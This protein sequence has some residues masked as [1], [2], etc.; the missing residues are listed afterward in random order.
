MAI[1]DDDIERIRSSVSI[2]DVISQH[3]QLRRTGRNWVGLC[4]FHGEK[5]PSFNVREE[6]GRYKCF[7]CDAAGDIF[8]FVQQMQHTDFVGAVEALASRAGIELT[9]TSGGQQRDRARRGRLVGAM[10]AAVEWYHQRLLTGEDAGPARSYL[11]ARGL[12]GDDVRTFRI[13]WAP[14]GW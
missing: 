4:P 9:Y 5:T 8:T 2:V 3:V 14:D 12:T 1:S 7:G 6:T 10:D 13:G 11:R